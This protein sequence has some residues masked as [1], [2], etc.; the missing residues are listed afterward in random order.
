MVVNNTVNEAGDTILIKLVEPYKKVK[1][2][3]SYTDVTV[4]EDTNNYFSKWF[5]WSTDNK[6]FSD[7]IELD[8][9]NLAN[10]ELD[11]AND[12]WI[13]YKYEA[14]EIETGHTMEFTSIALEVVTAAG[15]LQEVVQVQTSACDPSTPGCVGNLIIEDCCGDDNTFKP[16]AWM[17]GANCLY[18]QLSQ[19]TTKIFG[20]CV[21]Y[22]RVEPDKESE[23]VILREYSIFNRNK[24][25]DIQVLVPDNE[26]PPNDFQ[27]D[28]FE[29]MGFEGFEIHITRREFETAFGAKSRP[30]ERDSI[31]FPINQRMYTV[32]SVALA[33]EIN[34]M[35]TYYKIKL[36]KFED[37]Q[38]TIDTPEIEAE[39]DELVV[40]MGEV[41]EDKTKDEF[42]KV[43][44]PQE[45]K[46]IGQG[47]YDYVR[48]EINTTI[49]IADEKINNN[50][51]IVSKNYYNLSKM[52]YNSVAVKYRIKAENKET[53]DKAFTFWFRP[54]FAQE[55]PRLNVSTL[56]DSSG[57]LKVNTTPLHGLKVGDYVEFYG[58]SDYEK[59]VYRVVTV[60]SGNEFVVDATFI[61][62]TIVTPGVTKIRYKQR[63][64]VLYGY[65]ITNPT[66]NGMSIDLFQGYVIVTINGARYN[67]PSDI[68]IY[69][70]DTWHAVVVNLSNKFK[71]LSVHLYKLDKSETYTIPQN[72]DSSMTSIKY[73]S[74]SLDS[75]VSFNSDDMW[76]LLGSPID[77]TN[78]RIFKTP[79]EEE[80][81]NAVLNQ[82]VV[83]DTQLALL[84]DNAVPQIKLA[85]FE[86]PR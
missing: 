80:S 67:F 28:P 41:F 79:I 61:T 72:E 22:Y 65:N 84:I 6:T 49:E 7:F 58:N 86:N 69:T 81:H 54:K 27:F 60:N 18:D 4:G 1:S 26:F 73:E 11:P 29:G 33:D 55:K 51:T 56:S 78:I 15:R 12:F 9:L 77:L 70:A 37:S 21:R 71:Q 75:T 34:A 10:L 38:S 83:R 3:I 8:N 17:F 76:A 16:Y 47:D 45:Y 35:H 43:T 5:R 68:D 62:G 50:W 59:H 24:V 82:Y 40:G 57:L 20:H 14:V 39:L 25:R 44:K 31:Y 19:V 32:N 66:N 42:L 30:R 74:I 46:T 64:P 52:V 13:E 85:K 36:R 48:S 23:D 2:I 63:A 53:D